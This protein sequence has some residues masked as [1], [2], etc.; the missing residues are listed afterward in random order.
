MWVFLEAQ[1]G[2]W[3]CSLG[4]TPVWP[5][6]HDKHGWVSCREVVMDNGCG[7]IREEPQIPCSVS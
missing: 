7:L 3:C 4:L 6:K 1:P 5:R 2:S